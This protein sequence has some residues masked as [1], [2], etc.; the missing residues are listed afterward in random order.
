[1][2]LKAANDN[3]PRTLGRLIARS[4]VSAGL[5]GLIAGVSWAHWLGGS[6]APSRTIGTPS[7]GPV[8]VPAS[9]SLG[10]LTFAGPVEAAPPR[11]G[12]GDATGDGMN[13]TERLTQI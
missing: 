3:T 4:V 11:A 2:I 8:R 10:N 5:V 1:M 7:P 13:G 6:S 12:L 9:G